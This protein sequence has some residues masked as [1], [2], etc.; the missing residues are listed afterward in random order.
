VSFAKRKLIGMRQSSVAGLAQRQAKERTIRKLCVLG[1]RLYLLAFCVLFLALAARAFDSPLDL[2][3]DGVEHRYNRAKTLSI[4]FTETYQAGGRQR[5]PEMGHL[6]LKK[7]GRMRWTYTKPEG[8]LFVSDGKNVF[9]YTAADN[10][11]ERSR[12]KASEDMRAP[13]AF[14]LG[15][16]DM[17][18][19]FKSFETRIAPDGTWLVAQAANDRLPYERVEMLI[20]KDYAIRQ[21]TVNSRDQSVL[22]FQFRNEVSNP[23]VDANSFRFS[24]PPD[25]EVVDAV[26]TGSGDN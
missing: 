2:L 21:L 13:M 20:G 6:L 25:A 16:L 8:K 4:D 22:T 9:L 12:L 7:P 26:A 10:R 23:A 19:E 11:V 3:V 15:K 18:R 24:V 5:P 1:G 14:L 17:K